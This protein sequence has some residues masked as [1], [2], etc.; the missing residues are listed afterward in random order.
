MAFNSN[1]TATESDLKAMLYKRCNLKSRGI[2]AVLTTLILYQFVMLNQDMILEYI[3]AVRDYCGYLSCRKFTRKFRHYDDYVFENGS[4]PEMNSSN[5][6]MAMYGI[7]DRV[8]AWVSDFD[9]DHNALLCSD[10]LRFMPDGVMQFI[11]NFRRFTHMHGLTRGCLRYMQ[12]EA[13]LLELTRTELDTIATRFSR[14][15]TWNISLENSYKFEC[16]PDYM[17]R[18][19]WPFVSQ[20]GLE[21]AATFTYHGENSI[22]S[23]SWSPTDVQSGDVISVRGK[24]VSPQFWKRKHPRIQSQYIVLVQTEAEDVTPGLYHTMQTDD[25][26]GIFYSLNHDEQHAGMHSKFKPIPLG[27]VWSTVGFVLIQQHY[28][29][30]LWTHSSRANVVLWMM[31]MRSGERETAFNELSRNL[32]AMLKKNDYANVFEIYKTVKFVASPFGAG[33]DCHRTWEAIAMGAVP[34]VR[35]HAGLNPLFVGQPVLIV[36]KWSDVTVE[37]LNSWTYPAHKTAYDSLWLSTWYHRIEDGKRRL[38]AT[39]KHSA[40]Q[41]R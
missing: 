18:V 25:R 4:A 20:E 21:S 38:L 7:I 17:R 29:A 30:P 6:D 27:Q 31:S 39:N 28:A 1:A 32:G 9:T 13:V 41:G 10:E 12:I 15:G 22:L 8:L 3:S 5:V 16:V 2:F 36:D 26:V 40:L 14:V 34:I 33:P 11:P 24:R 19:A 35:R 23:K 37:L